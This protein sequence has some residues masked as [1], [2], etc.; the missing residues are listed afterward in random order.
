MGRVGEHVEEA[1]LDRAQGGHAR[2]VGGQR[3]GVARGVDD[4]GRVA[5]VQVGG[6]VGPD[7]S[8]RRVDDDH[9]GHVLG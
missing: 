1:S 9:V 4:A 6:Q 5:L 3:G 7:A 2:Q 8:T